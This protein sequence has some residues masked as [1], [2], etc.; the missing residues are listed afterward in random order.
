MGEGLPFSM[1][2]VDNCNAWVPNR[3]KYP[4]KKKIADYF[5]AN[6]HI[7]TSGNFHTPALLNTM[8]VV[9]ADRIMFS[10][11]WPFENIDHAAIWFDAATIS[12][13]DR[14]KIGRTN[15]QKLFKLK[16]ACTGTRATSCLSRGAQ[17][18]IAHESRHR[19][20]R[21]DDGSARR[22]PQRVTEV[23]GRLDRTGARRATQPF[24][25]LQFDRVFPDDIY[26]EML[27]EM[28]QARATIARCPAATTA[29]S[30]TTA[31]ATRVKIDLFPEYIRNLPPQ[32]R[33]LWDV[34]GR[35][36]CSNEVQGRVHAPARAGPGAPL[37]RRATR[38]VGMFP[39][40]MLT[41]D[42]PNTK[43]RRTPTRTWK[44][45]TVQF[46][47][48]PRRHDRA[49]RHDLPRQAAGRHACRRRSRC[50]SRPTPATPSRSATTPGIRPIR[51]GPR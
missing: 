21:H 29:T 16:G 45:I 14:I 31:R 37:R 36:L 8:M 20:S 24:Y 43:S 12:E 28:P 47:L 49:H 48:P 46:Y 4:A 9:G 15:A 13:E 18:V 33:E 30:S 39:I 25:H 34:V 27:R 44:G 38:D 26:A 35:A 23:R 51:S 50:R 41:R 11:D 32:K 3:N 40:P 42:V 2:R 5:Q 22:Q 10:T 19:G 1:W 6:F 7:T 17:S